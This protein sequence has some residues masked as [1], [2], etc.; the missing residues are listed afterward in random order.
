MKIQIG[1]RMGLVIGL[2][3]LVGVLAVTNDEVAIALIESLAG[4]LTAL[5]GFGT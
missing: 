4:I 2:L 1:W 5:A 3:A